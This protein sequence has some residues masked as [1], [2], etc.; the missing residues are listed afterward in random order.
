MSASLPGAGGR[1]GIDDVLVAL[2][3]VGAVAGRVERGHGG[4]RVAGK[5]SWVRGAGG[6]EGG[7]EEEGRNEVVVVVVAAAAAAA[8]A[9]VVSSGR[10]TAEQQNSRTAEQQ[11]SRTA[12]QQNKRA[13]AQRVRGCTRVSASVQVGA[14]E[15]A[16]LGSDDG[17]QAATAMSYMAWR[18]TTTQQPAPCVLAAPSPPLCHDKPPASIRQLTPPS[19]RFFLARQAR[20]ASCCCT[21]A[22]LQLPARLHPLVVPFMSLA[23]P[24][25]ALPCSPPQAVAP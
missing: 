3:D 24:A 12:V 17:G 16:Q 22:L 21:A 1:G 18:C 19:H 23:C 20:G 2:C 13:T 25:A 7:R 6:R 14:R 4:R 15:R 10:R 8:A 9:V 5:L 11:N